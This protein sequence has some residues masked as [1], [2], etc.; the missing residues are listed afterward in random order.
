M[1]VRYTVPAQVD[2]DDLYN[3]VSDNNPFAAERIKRQIRVD[4]EL[5]GELP[6]IARESDY[7]G[8]RIRKVRRYP[9]LIFY[10]VQEDEVHIL[11]VRHGARRWPWEDEG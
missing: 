5:L 11:R 3:F 8:I 1:K 6:Y 7:P 10:S 9:Y 2:L 4:A